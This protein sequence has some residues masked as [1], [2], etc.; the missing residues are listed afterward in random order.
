VVAIVSGG[1]KIAG[2]ICGC[3]MAGEILKERRWGSERSEDMAAMIKL[4]EE[5]E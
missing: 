5:K 2:A 1:L 4:Q 3:V